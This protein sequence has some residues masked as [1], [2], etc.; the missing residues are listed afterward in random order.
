MD[1]IIE[2]LAE[3]GRDVRRRQRGLLLSTSRR[4]KGLEFDH[5]AVLDGGWERFG[6]DEDP[7]ATRRLYYVAMTRARRTLAL[8]H[9]VE[10]R[11]PLSCDATRRDFGLALEP[12]SA[13]QAEIAGQL[14]ERTRQFGLS[15]GDRACLALG[16]DRGETVYTADRAWLQ[17]A[18]GVDVETI[19]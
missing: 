4:A 2:R 3:W 7:D 6:E 17:L 18:L 9:L 16:S 12:F 14:E 13:A 15:L 1:H 10:S 8:A 19:R 11:P 5:V